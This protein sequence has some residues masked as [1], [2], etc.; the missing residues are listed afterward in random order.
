[1]NII[2]LPYGSKGFY[3]RPDTSLNRDSNDYFCPEEVTE[4][5]AAVF[6]YAKAIKAGK[7]VASKFAGRYYSVI[8]WGIHLYVPSL[9]NGTPEGWWM[10]R[11]LDSST[12][13]WEDTPAEQAPAEYIETINAAFEATSKYVSF[14]TGDCIAVEVEPATTIKKGEPSFTCN[15]KHINIIW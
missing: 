13:I 15:N 14:R 8:G 10:S 4:L 2:T 12:F 5:A 11:S 6:I 9:D 3:V 7:C 1:M